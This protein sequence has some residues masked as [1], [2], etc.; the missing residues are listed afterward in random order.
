MYSSFALSTSHNH[1][2]P[3]LSLSFQTK[4]VDPLNITNTPFPSCLNPWQSLFCFLSLSLTTVGPSWAKSWWYWSF[5]DLFQLSRRSSRFHPSA[6][7]RILFLLLGWIAFHCTYTPCFTYPC[8]CWWTF[9][10]SLWLT[11][12]N[13]ARNMDVLLHSVLR[14]KSL[15]TVLTKEEVITWGCEYQEVWGS[16]GPSQRL[17]TILLKA[18]LIIVLCSAMPPTGYTFKL[19]YFNFD[20]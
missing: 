5:C 18:V 19:V 12:K 6:R 11:W 20:T 4:T 9:V 16:W 17:P 2:S 1:S 8:V 13:A 15:N 3:E 10:S 7:V 14:N